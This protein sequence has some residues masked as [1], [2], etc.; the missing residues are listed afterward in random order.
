[1]YAVYTYLYPVVRV[2]I[3]TWMRPCTHDS[4]STSQRIDPLYCR[5][6][7]RKL[8][9]IVKIVKDRGYCQVYCQDR[10]CIVTSLWVPTRLEL[11]RSAAWT[12]AHAL[13]PHRFI[14]LVKG[15]K[16]VCLTKTLLLRFLIQS[17]RQ[18]SARRLVLQVT[19]IH[20]NVTI[21][22]LIADFTFTIAF[23][24]TIID[25]IIY[26]RPHLITKSAQTKTLHECITVIHEFYIAT[27]SFTHEELCSK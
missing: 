23:E 15:S 5:G 21:T 7:S 17:Q 9:S 4:Y 11:I 27:R 20:L 10:W 24:R 2:I 3:Y 25:K 13:H 8:R 26:P 16:S 12:R 1:M 19:Y 22:A 18:Y 6:V 14:D